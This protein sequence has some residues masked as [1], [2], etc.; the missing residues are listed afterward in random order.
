[1]SRNSFEGM[2]TSQLGA[3]LRSVATLSA[4]GSEGGG[5]GGEESV[6]YE[7]H[8]NK[9]VNESQTGTDTDKPHVNLDV[10]DGEGQEIGSGS[11]PLAVSRTASI[12]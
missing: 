10:H 1:M 6:P 5:G 2:T 7:S 11:S 12:H 3:S 8:V 9:D 4:R